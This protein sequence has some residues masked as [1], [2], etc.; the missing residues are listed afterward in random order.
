VFGKKNDSLIEGAIAKRGVS[1]KELF[2]EFGRRRLRVHLK[3]LNVENEKV[4][5]S[6]RGFG[7]QPPNLGKLV[8]VILY[9]GLIIRLNLGSFAAHE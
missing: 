9:Y 7:N 1:E 5:T 2:I 4:K 6:M 8:V 3:R